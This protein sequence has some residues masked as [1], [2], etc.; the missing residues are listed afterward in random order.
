MGWSNLEKWL[1]S[2]RNKWYRQKGSSTAKR[3]QA[4]RAGTLEKTFKKRNMGRYLSILKAIALGDHTVSEIA[5][6]AVSRT[7]SLPVY[8]DFLQMTGL[9]LKLDKRYRL[10]DPFL[11]FWLRAC[12]RV[13][14]ASALS[15]KEKLSAFHA[16]TQDLLNAIR[17]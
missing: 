10:A 17:S 7:T 15:A 3:G 1:L 9:I 6:A 11:E 4:R 2:K 5:S 16:V 14:E 13:Q 12:L 8:L